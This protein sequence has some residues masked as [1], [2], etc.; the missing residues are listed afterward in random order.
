MR[1]LIIHIRQREAGDFDKDSLLLQYKTSSQPQFLI[2]NIHNSLSHHFAQGSRLVGQT[3]DLMDQRESLFLLMHRL[4][5][6]K[7]FLPQ[8]FLSHSPLASKWKV[9]S[10][11]FSEFSMPRYLYFSLLVEGMAL[12]DPSIPLTYSRYSCV[13]LGFVASPCI[14]AR[15]NK[16]QD[17]ALLSKHSH[18]PSPSC[19]TELSH[20]LFHSPSPPK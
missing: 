11:V 16:W 2:N 6:T 1:I 15:I 13:R 4:E 5:Y 10:K 19:P 3:R 9:L 17:P 18:L 7:Q 12:C 20:L 14:L 8:H